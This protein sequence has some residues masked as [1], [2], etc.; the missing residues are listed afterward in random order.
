MK[1]M[2]C[3]DPAVGM[4]PVPILAAIPLGNESKESPEQSIFP[5]RWIPARLVIFPRK[6][7]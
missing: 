1:A 5:G 4:A 6:A 2:I 7:S 3:T